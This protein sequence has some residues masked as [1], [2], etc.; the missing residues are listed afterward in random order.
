MKNFFPL[1]IIAYLLYSVA[2]CGN[3]GVTDPTAG[4]TTFSMSQQ[5]GTGGAIDFLAKPSVDVK[6][7]KVVCNLPS[8]AVSDT[9]VITTPN[10]TFSKDSFYIVNSY[11]GVQTGQ[12]WNFVY[13]GSTV[14]GN[15]GF[16][17]TTNYTVP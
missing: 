2:G 15:A 3:N 5:T 7:T 14:S 16:T 10:Y 8:S 4:N 9:V 17:V 13:T 1:I 6:L 11:T 12:Q